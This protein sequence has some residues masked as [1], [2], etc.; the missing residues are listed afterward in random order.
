MKVNRSNVNASVRKTLLMGD[1]ILTNVNTNGLKRN[2][3]KHS[4]SGARVSSLLDEIPI[5]DMTVFSDVI[6]YIG[7]NDA[8]GKVDD[9]LFEET[10]DRLIGQ[11]KGSNRDCKIFLCKIAPRG[12]TE[13]AKYNRCID[14]LA[15]KWRNQQVKAIQQTEQYFYGRNGL[16]VARYFSDDGI[17]LSTPGLKRLL[18]AMNTS[19]GIVSDFERCV[20]T[21]RQQGRRGRNG[22]R[23]LATSNR[24][25]ATGQSQGQRHNTKQGRFNGTRPRAERFNR[26][27]KRQCYACYMIGHIASECWDATSQ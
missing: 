12:D 19:T 15:D 17:H 14:R 23:S 26:N 11:I 4:K 22:Q 16:P 3:Q 1:S 9:K 24:E 7:G 21:R 13:V 10:Y 2:T 20:Y 18:D 5:Y 27:S 6:I 25:T 8:S